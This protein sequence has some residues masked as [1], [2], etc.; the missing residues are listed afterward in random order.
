M[1]SGILPGSAVPAS[2]RRRNA[3]STETL[4]RVRAAIA[5]LRNHPRRSLGLSYLI[6]ELRSPR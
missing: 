4:E 5:A 1:I 2:G 3:T 6:A